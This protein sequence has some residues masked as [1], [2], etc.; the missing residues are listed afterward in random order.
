MNELFAPL[1]R[2][3]L[4]YAAR[5][6]FHICMYVILYHFQDIITFVVH[7]TAHDLQQSFIFL[8]N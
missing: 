2:A 4:D 6:K 1:I 7:V 5:Y 3:M 8:I